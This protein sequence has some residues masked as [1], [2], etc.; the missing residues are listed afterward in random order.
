MDNNMTE[1][2]VRAEQLKVDPSQALEA[3]D[4]IAVDARRSV[5]HLPAALMAP[6]LGI[7]LMGAACA[8]SP[9]TTDR[10]HI[11]DQTSSAPTG[12]AENLPGQQPPLEVKRPEGIDPEKWERLTPQKKKEVAEDRARIRARADIVAGREPTSLITSTPEKPSET[13]TVGPD[14]FKTAIAI[15]GT[16]PAEPY[17]GPQGTGIGRTG[18]G[19]VDA[20][21]TGVDAA[22]VAAKFAVGIGLIV[23]II[24][25]GPGIVLKAGWEA[26]KLPFR[27]VGGIGRFLWI[28]GREAV[29]R[30]SRR[31]LPEDVED[32]YYE[33]R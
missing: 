27:I 10:L 15:A 30:P 29:G 32:E 20:V 28:H 11:G 22:W 24:K 6:L 19:V 33:P 9:P 25:K 8:D 12:R 7:A 26:V 3:V 14:G 18:I 2:E 23:L 13:P 16:P 17:K 4:R 21:L 31:R 1:Q 5:L